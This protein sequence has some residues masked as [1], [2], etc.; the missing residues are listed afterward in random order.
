MVKDI[1]TKH[2]VRSFKIEGIG[3]PTNIWSFF[4]QLN[5]EN[6]ERTIYLLCTL[7]LP[8]MSAAHAKGIALNSRMEDTLEGMWN[9]AVVAYFKSTIPAFAWTYWGKNH[10]IFR[11]SA[12]VGTKHLPKESQKCYFLSQFPQHSELSRQSLAIWRLQKRIARIFNGTLNMWNVILKG[13]I[14]FQE[15]LAC[16]YLLSHENKVRPNT[17]SV[18]RKKADKWHGVK[19]RFMPP[20]TKSTQKE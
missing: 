11:V 20:V 15:G 14:C 6:Q 1:R 7:Y 8:M 4:R 9:R 10:E 5:D 2:I 17:A 18:A 16:Q 19:L 3:S 12:E 13:K